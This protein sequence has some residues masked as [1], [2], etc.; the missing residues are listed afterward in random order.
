M[1]AVLARALVVSFVLAVAGGAAVLPGCATVGA[2]LPD[3][4]AAIVDGGQILDAIAAFMAS[5]FANHPDPVAQ[6]KVADA[7]AKCRAALNVAVR[8][9][10]G[11]DAANSANVDQA[12]ADFEGAYL[13]LLELV[14][15]YGVKPAPMPSTRLAA[16][17]SRL[18]VPHPLAFRLSAQKGR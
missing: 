13:A 2:A 18:T 10:Q 1:R 3:I 12:F 9:A 6:T 14:K 8:A 17:P 7:L 4:L 15:P 5:Y 11:A 16:E